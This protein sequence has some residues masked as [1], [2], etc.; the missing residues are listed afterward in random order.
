M[1]NSMWHYYNQTELPVDESFSLSIA[2]MLSE[3]ESFY[4]KS[5]PYFSVLSLLPV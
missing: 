5:H 3:E 1:A 4:F 2:L